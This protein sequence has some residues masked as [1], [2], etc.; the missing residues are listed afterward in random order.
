MIETRVSDADQTRWE[1]LSQRSREADGSFL[2]AVTSTRVY[3]RP[4]CGSR[5]PRRENVRFFDR[6]DQAEQAG[7]RACKRCQPTLQTS[8]EQDVEAIRRACTLIEEA[9]EPP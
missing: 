3:C 4:G 1:L 2:Y 7:F 6:P 8:P 9:D 5:L